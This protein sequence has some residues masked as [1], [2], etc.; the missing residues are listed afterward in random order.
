MRFQ[1]LSVNTLFSSYRFI[2][3]VPVCYIP[4]VETKE[5]EC[6][7]FL[8]WRL[9]SENDYQSSRNINRQAA[10]KC[11]YSRRL[12]LC[13]SLSALSVCL[14]LVYL[15]ISYLNNT[16]HKLEEFLFGLQTLMIDLLSCYL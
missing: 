2:H 6:W 16:D 9:N 11:L 15:S 7:K 3:L 10:I 14:L 5:R 4:R 12:C 1:H 13:L 8:D